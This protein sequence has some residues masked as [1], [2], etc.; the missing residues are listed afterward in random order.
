MSYFS[1]R[2]SPERMCISPSNKG[3]IIAHSKV[4]VSNND[5]RLLLNSVCI[6]I[7]DI[8]PINIR[9]DTGKLVLDIRLIG[10]VI[11]MINVGIP[12]ITKPHIRSIS[13]EKYV[14]YPSWR[15]FCR[16]ITRNITIEIYTF[17]IMSVCLYN[18]VK[19]QSSPRYLY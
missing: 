19:R 2:I 7:P 5:I 13:S 1:S 6:R 4:G 15:V 14:E 9:A 3:F 18:R 17:Q 12:D 16:C 11:R 8:C 10:L